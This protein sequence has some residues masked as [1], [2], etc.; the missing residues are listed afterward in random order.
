MLKEPIGDIEPLLALTV[1][2]MLVLALRL[3]T[4]MMMVPIFPMV[5]VSTSA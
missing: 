4:Q 5:F 1:V 3:M 2:V